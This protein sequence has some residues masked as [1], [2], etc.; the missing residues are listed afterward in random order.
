MVPV[1]SFLETRVLG[2]LA[3]KE[4]TVP[5]TYPL[6][7][8]A[9]VAGCNQKTSRDPVIN[10]TETEV[11][12]ALDNLKGMSLVIESSG[13]RVARYSHNI[14][15]VLKIPKQS[16]ALLTVLMVRG[17]QTAGELRTHASRMTSLPDLPAVISI[18]DGLKAA[19]TPFVEELPREPG[20][21]ANRYRHLIGEPGSRDARGGT[22]AGESHPAESA[23]KMAG[24]IAHGAVAGSRVD[25]GHLE[26]RVARLERDVAEL[27]SMI[28]QLRETRGVVESPHAV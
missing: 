6:S 8:N 24:T 17:P 15:R 21:S 26:E 4:R 16:V 14:E 11:Q 9:L 13:G 7:L 20:R 27:R 18:L 3:E 22:A 1:L 25:S 19:A 28:E 5:D 2:V 12:A 23:E 10:A